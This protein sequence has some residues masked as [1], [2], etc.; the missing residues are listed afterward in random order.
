MATMSE[1]IAQVQELEKATTDLLEATNVSKRSLDDSVKSSEENANKS[2]SSADR[3]Q[4]EADKSAQS[5]TA[6]ANSAKLAEG[7]ANRADTIANLETVRDALRLAV[8]PTPDFYLPL[9]SNLLIREGNGKPVKVDVSPEQDGSVLSTVPNLYQANFERLSRATYIDNH[10]VLRIAEI[11]EPRF[12]KEGMLL[13]GESTNKIYN[14]SVLR[15]VNNGG[16]SEKAT[17]EISPDKSPDQKSEAYRCVMPSYTGGGWQVLCWDNGNTLVGS[18]RTLSIWLKGSGKI[19]LN[20][21]QGNG[22]GEIGRTDIELTEKWQRYHFTVLEKTKSEGGLYITKKTPN[23]YVEF[24]FAFPQIEDLPFPSSYIPT[25]G[26]PATRASDKLNV[27][28]KNIPLESGTFGLTVKLHGYNSRSWVC[29]GGVASTP[30][31]L[32]IESKDCIT[33]SISG[34]ANKNVK[35]IGYGKIYVTYANEVS[36]LYHNGVE[37]SSGKKSYASV[38]NGEQFSIG[39]FGSNYFMPIYGHVNDFTVWNIPLT[40]EQVASI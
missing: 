15:T 4:N 40:K 9:K 26:S 37:I 36:T 29:G 25:S 18:P 24:D 27:D 28:F 17:V 7:A 19:Y 34:T 12:E 33:S 1:L 22:V 20:D 10:G 38:E 6:A 16:Q 21:C 11:N 32:V 39:S 30:Y 8:V 23:S 35:V 2:E 13:E 3:S 14:S 5:S 31:G